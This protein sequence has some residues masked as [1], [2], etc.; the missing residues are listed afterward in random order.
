MKNAQAVVVL[1]SGAGG[2]VRDKRLRRWLSRGCVTFDPPRFEV[3]DRV[4]KIIDAPLPVGGYAALRFWGQTGER[5]AAWIAAADP[6]HLETRLRDLRVRALLPGQVSRD[7]LRTL[8]EFLHSELGGNGQIDFARLGSFGYLRGDSGFETPAVSAA[9]AEGHVPDRFTPAGD[10]ARTYHRLLG[11]LQMCLHGHDVND[12]REN[13]GLP[14]INSLWLW[15]GGLAPAV[16][17]RSLPP[18]Y[19]ADPLFKGYWVSCGGAVAPWQGGFDHCIDGAPEGFV[20]VSPE[21]APE[22]SGDFLE[23]GLFRLKQLLHAGDIRS[24]TLLFR[25]G[26]MVTIGRIDKIR[27]WRGISPILEERIN[28]D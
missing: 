12:R 2:R 4:L 9:V 13:A 11:E 7:E 28:D 23:S 21:P 27:F 8:F 26:L 10:A 20:A 1:P 24:L 15:G 14:A 19:S 16:T 6:V 22:E 25:D 17:E 5:S 3:L 18:L